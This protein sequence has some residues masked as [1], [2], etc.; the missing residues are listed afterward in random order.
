MPAANA[1]STEPRLSRPSARCDRSSTKVQP[2]NE[3]SQFEKVLLP[4]VPMIER[5]RE[6]RQAG[7]DDPERRRQARLV[8]AR[9]ANAQLLW[10]AE[11]EQLIALYVR[12]F[13]DGLAT[14]DVATLPID[15]KDRRLS[16]GR[17]SLEPKGLPS[18][19]R[20]PGRHPFDHRGRV[21]RRF[22]VEMQRMASGLQADR[23]PCRS[24]IDA[25]NRAM[26]ERADC[27]TAIE[28]LAP[29]LS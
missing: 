26:C 12:R 2:R 10:A 16:F 1:M 20:Y 5:V 13:G 23:T 8:R 24:V 28:V 25:A 27:R 14:R 9:K 15:P 19:R 22:A 29:W 6:R 7:R 18:D 11:P 4:C 3:R 21:L 17:P